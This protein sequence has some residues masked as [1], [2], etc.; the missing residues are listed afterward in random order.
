[1]DFLAANHV[2]I[3]RLHGQTW[4]RRYFSHDYWPRTV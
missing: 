2:S 4:S 1:M 3:V